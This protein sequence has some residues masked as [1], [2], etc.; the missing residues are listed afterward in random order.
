MSLLPFPMLCLELGEHGV[1][2]KWERLL[3]IWGR[4]SLGLCLPL[5]VTHSRSEGDVPGHSVILLPLVLLVTFTV[6]VNS[7]V[8]SVIDDLF[9]LG[10]RI[11]R[12][13]VT[14]ARTPFCS[15]H[16]K[17]IYKEPQHKV[18]DGVRGARIFFTLTTTCDFSP[19][20]H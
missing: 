13:E 8:T 7:T 14:D 20:L 3:Q 12:A 2:K 10:T 17:Q 1:L 16:A 4:P 19:Q 18:L 5:S 9:R 6:S 11:R 15:R